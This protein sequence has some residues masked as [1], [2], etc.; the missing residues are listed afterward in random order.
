MTPEQTGQMLKQTIITGGFSRR[1]IFVYGKTQ[2]K[3]VPFITLTQAQIMA[4]KYLTAELIEI[5]NG[6]WKGEFFMSPEARAWFEAWY[7]AKHEELQKPHPAV[8]KNWLKSK[9]VILI[10][11]AMLLVIA[12]MRNPESRVI[13]LRH[14]E[15]GLTML[16]SIEPDL[17]RIFAGAGKNPG[18]ELANKILM[19]LQE[20]GG[21]GLTRKQILAQ[22]YHEGPT[23]EIDEALSFLTTT[24][25][26]SLVSVQLNPQT[27][28][29]AMYRFVG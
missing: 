11:V 13:H 14:L 25:K 18:A 19:Q 8:V 24:N 15:R 4:H 23:R 27:P 9:D 26:A 5:A 10:K 12:E 16:D 7:N 6:K 21:R 22:F 20:T 28:A 29:V 1:V 17:T 2:S 3:P